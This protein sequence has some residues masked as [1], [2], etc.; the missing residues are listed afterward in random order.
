MHSKRQPL[1]YAVVLFKNRPHTSYAQKCS[2]AASIT[3]KLTVFFA[4]H[5]KYLFHSDT[6]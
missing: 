3:N 5:A 2:F 1:G 4:N 6:R